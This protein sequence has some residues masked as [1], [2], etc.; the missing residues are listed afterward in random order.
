[1]TE[2]HASDVFEKIIVPA[3]RR[4]PWFFK[5]T[6]EGTTNPK[7]GFSFNAPA[8]KITKSNAGSEEVD[9]LESWLNFGSSDI[10]VYDGS[11][12]QRYHGDEIGKTENVDIVRRHIVVMRAL[13]QGKRIIGKSIYT[14]TAGEIKRGK[15]PSRS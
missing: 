15:I 1:M 11:K 7:S 14:S 5:P 8:V 6:M 2:T 4:M 10:S 3:W 12:L 9:A 13:T